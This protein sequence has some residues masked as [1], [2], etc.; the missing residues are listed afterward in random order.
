[1]R[2]LDIAERAKQEKPWSVLIKDF[3]DRSV[4]HPYF[5]RDAKVLAALPVGKRFSCVDFPG[6]HTFLF[7]EA[8]RRGLIKIVGKRFRPPSGLRHWLI[9]EKVL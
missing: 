7:T 1:M 4:F 3:S 6:I 5:A 2:L 9:Y 8:E